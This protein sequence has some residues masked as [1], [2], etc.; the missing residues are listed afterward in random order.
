MTS[1]AVRIVA[2]FFVWH[3]VL[4]RLGIRLQT[5]LSARIWVSL[6]LLRIAS[7]VGRVP[8]ALSVLPLAALCRG[9]LA[10]QSGAR[11]HFDSLAP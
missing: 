7:R 4:R 5:R 1:S 9:V 11:D 2:G 10:Q 3:F 8:L 6:E